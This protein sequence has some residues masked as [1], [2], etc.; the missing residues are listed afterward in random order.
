MEVT[1]KGGIFSYPENIDFGIVSLPEIY[2]TDSNEFSKKFSDVS[3]KNLFHF[4]VPTNRFDKKY[5]LFLINNEES[6]LKITV[7]I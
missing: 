2:R 5:D 6:P 7:I 3:L 4:N 1:K